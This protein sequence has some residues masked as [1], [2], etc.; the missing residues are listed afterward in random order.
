MPGK[1]TADDEL[2][3]L[4]PGSIVRRKIRGAYRFY[5]QWREDGRTRSRYLKP[6]EV[7]PL[8]RQIERR[9]ALL[10]RADRSDEAKVR[11]VF[12]ADPPPPPLGDALT[13]RM[14]HEFALGAKRFTPRRMLPDVL[15]F[16][17]RDASDRALLLDGHAGTGRTTLMRH[18]AL[19]MTDEEREATAYVR[20]CDSVQPDT[21]NAALAAL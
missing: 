21:L 17:R 11:G 16:L 10:R 5:H 8:R 4:P 7:L 13:G 12:A 18:A 15:D 20:L 9:K 19:A 2:S 1:D 14:L 3:G 6:D